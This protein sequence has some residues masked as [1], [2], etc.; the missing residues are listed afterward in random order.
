MAINL[1]KNH[2]I[3]FELQKNQKSIKQSTIIKCEEQQNKFSR[4]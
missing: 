2:F 3:Y 1:S 4:F